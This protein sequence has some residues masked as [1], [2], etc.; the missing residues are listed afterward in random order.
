MNIRA[1]ISCTSSMRRTRQ[2]QQ[3]QQG[4]F[5]LLEVLIAV[6][7][8][9][10]GLLGLAAVFPAVLSQQRSA[11]DASLGAATARSAQDFLAR[12]SLN[13]PSPLYDASGNPLD[14]TNSGNAAQRRGWDILVA[15]PDWSKQEEWT[16]AGEPDNLLLDSATGD[17]T[18][19]TGT[20]KVWVALA[21][22]LS[23]PPLEVGEAPK[24]VWD[25]ALRRSIGTNFGRI[26]IGTRGQAVQD[27]PARAQDRVQVAVFVRRIDNGIR[28]ASGK[29][30]AQVLTGKDLA[31][32]ND[33]RVPVAQ[34]GQGRPT[35][36]GVGSGGTGTLN[37]S[38]IQR[39]T[40]TVRPPTGA[41]LDE[42]VIE[43]SSLSAFA[44]Q[45]G[46]KLVDQFGIIHTVTSVVVNETGP[47]PVVEYLKI[48]PPISGDLVGIGSNSAEGA[49]SMLLTPQVP[50]GVQVFDVRR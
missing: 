4:G 35:L 39:V 17:V 32:A 45:V 27:Q 22:R 15:D 2:P 13:T 40:Y 25:F 48:A 28:T 41:G 49:L 18:V 33:R 37:Y 3:A 20:N 14:L 24:Y 31:S 21:D 36:D 34:D 50:V 8:L 1:N 12:S 9:S 26:D 44:E 5:S 47:R 19:G 23:P 38:N 46:Q 7:V 10:L 43:P 29:T 16:I 6:V 30:L 11:N 42:I